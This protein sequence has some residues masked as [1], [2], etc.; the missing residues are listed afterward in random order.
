[1]REQYLE[2]VSILSEQQLDESMKEI[3]STPAAVVI[4]ST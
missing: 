2:I 1:M 3:V 4:I